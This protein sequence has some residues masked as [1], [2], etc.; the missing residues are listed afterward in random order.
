[1]L[2]AKQ[3]LPFAFDWCSLVPH[4]HR[5]NANY[6]L[7]KPILPIPLN[8]LSGGRERRVRDLTPEKPRSCT[9]ERL[10][11]RGITLQ[12]PSRDKQ[13]D[14]ILR[15]EGGR[16]CLTDGGQ[17]RTGELSLLRLPMRRCLPAAV[18]L[19]RSSAIKRSLLFRVATLL[20]AARFGLCFAA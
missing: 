16:C 2:H 14:G 15:I 7:L 10:F 17:Q 12:V 6:N 3:S 8:R 18:N 13:L 4:S 19:R 5:P 11:S 20:F 1:M 9:G